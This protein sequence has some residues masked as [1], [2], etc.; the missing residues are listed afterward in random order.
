MSE[1]SAASVK[2][3]RD[4][5]LAGMADC[6]KALEEAGGDAEKAADWLR[7]KG[8]LKAGQ[9]QGRSACEGLVASYIHGGGRIGVLLEV[10]CQTDFVARTDD[11]KNFCRDVAMHVAGHDPPPR[12][13]SEDEIPAQAA[14]KERGFLTDKAREAGS[15]KP[16]SI[17]SKIVDGQLAKW[18]REQCLLDQGFVRDPSTTVR[19][20]MLELSARTGEKVSVRRFARFVMGEG[21][22]KKDV[23]FAAEVAAQV[24]AQSPG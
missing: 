21:L 8:L 5:T 23:D 14:E 16:D 9:A 11:F 19:D 7:K 2:E 22:V 1:I 18:R 13:V 17:I 24:A 20:L 4:K 15:G 3:L 6:K 12:C 10:N